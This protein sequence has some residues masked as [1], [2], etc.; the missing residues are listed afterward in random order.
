[1]SEMI[2]A[3]GAIRDPSEIAA[4][5]TELDEG[6]PAP[7]MGDPAMMTLPE[8]SME[9]AEDILEETGPILKDP[10]DPTEIE[11]LQVSLSSSLEQ[12]VNVRTE[13]L[14]SGYINRS[15]A[16]MLKNL[17]TSAESINSF[18]DRVPVSSFTEIDS[19]VNYTATCEGLGKSIVDTVMSIIRTIIKYIVAIGK[20]FVNFLTSRRRKDQQNDQADKAVEK[21]NQDLDKQA[22]ADHL[23]DLRAERVK[24]RKV[25][26]DAVSKKMQPHYTRLV[27][28]MIAQPAA[29][30]GDPLCR[31]ELLA[32]ARLCASS[33]VLRQ[34]NEASGWSHQAVINTVQ[35]QPYF[36]NQYS[37]MA[38]VYPKLSS[39]QLKD[40][41]SYPGML[42]VLQA[43]KAYIVGLS[44]Q[45]SDAEID[46]PCMEVVRKFNQNTPHVRFNGLLG[47]IE[48]NIKGNEQTL[49]AIEAN[50][51]KMKGTTFL[52]DDFFPSRQR[53]AQQVKD[54]QLILQ[55]LTQIQ[56]IFATA[57]DRT[58]QIAL[59]Y[60]RARG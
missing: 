20:W 58:S 26:V 11:A 36:I 39:L 13:L 16:N 32:F 37:N 59:E 47:A 60:A 56:S 7:V 53:A 1:M 10:K 19:K 35:E 22:A 33:E 55:E 46:D 23:D 31:E 49:K 34:I 3:S 18:F 2:S 5:S 12:L 28:L 27:E 48:T 38:K 29:G 44:T 17:T 54:K 4:S 50:T 41:C 43:F 9:E 25:R 21:K 24:E 14:A 42:T 52:P 40:M 8:I 51:E 6:V 15:E 57:R 45:P 30:P